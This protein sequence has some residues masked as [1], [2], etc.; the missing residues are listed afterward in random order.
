M[1]RQEKTAVNMLNRGISI[2]EIAQKTGLS[3]VWLQLQKERTV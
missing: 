1:N 3:K 2:N